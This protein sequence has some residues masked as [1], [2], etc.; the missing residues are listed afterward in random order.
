MFFVPLD[1]FPNG[2][3]ELIIPFREDAQGTEVPLKCSD[4]DKDA[5]QSS[6]RARV[7]CMK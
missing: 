7:F 2:D 3:I 6:Y 1:H 5:Q 4:V